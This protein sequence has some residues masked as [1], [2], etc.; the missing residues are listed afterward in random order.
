MIEYSTLSVSPSSLATGLPTI[1]TLASLRAER[2]LAML[3]VTHDQE[4]A[5]ALADRVA[6]MRDGLV[7][8]E[9]SPVDVYAAPRTAFVADF[10]GP[11][12]LLPAGIAGS[13]A[14]TPLG[15]F[16]VESAADGERLAVFR[17]EAV[18]V[19]DDGAA[20]CHGRVETSFYRGSHHLLVVA[21]EGADGRV[22]VRS[23][24]G[25]APGTRIALEADRPAFVD[26]G[27]AQRDRTETS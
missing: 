14:S 22:L 27:A 13:S 26:G 1:E 5:F 9:G 2:G 7:E 20:R 18:R 4:E 11:A 15:T 23:E 3:V 12:A 17:P 25:M 16:P 19:A 6:V 21:L 24:T 8:Q 10:V